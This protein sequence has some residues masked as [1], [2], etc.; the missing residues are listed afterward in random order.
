MRSQGSDNVIALIHRVLAWTFAVV[1]LMFLVAPNGVVHSINAVGSIFRI[2]P[3]APDSDLRIWLGLAVGYMVMVTMLAWQI[4]VAPRANRSLMPFLAAGKLTSSFTSLL[5]FVFHQAAFLYLLNFLVDGSIVLVVL[6]CYA[7]LGATEQ[8]GRSST[9]EGR[10]AEML[11]ALTETMVPDGGP[12]EPGARSED[13]S[14]SVWAY[15]RHLHPLGPLGLQVLLYLF[16]YAPFVFGPRRRRFS[17]LTPAD[18]ETSLSGWET[19][20]LAP[21]RQMLNGVKLAVML[22]FY[23]SPRVCAAIGYDG[24]Y[25]RDKLL[26]GPNADFHRVRLNAATPAEDNAR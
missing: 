21:R 11:A 8:V 19:S 4:S 7:W 5:F 1:G 3:P 9:P 24:G 23:D 20:R 16:E 2:F 15:F 10:A 6:G 14:R 13:L 22:Q 12:I 26:A 18:R 17:R 25:L